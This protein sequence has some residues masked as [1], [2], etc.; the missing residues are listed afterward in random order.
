MAL[1]MFRS[2]MAK[3]GTE[4]FHVDL[5]A[6]LEKIME[7]DA[8]GRP[9]FEDLVGDQVEAAPAEPPAVATEGTRPATDEKATEQATSFQ[10]ARL[11]RKKRRTIDPLV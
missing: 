9:P 8:G 2:S 6:E 7:N 4:E 10:E 5:D 3:R 1:E 11:E